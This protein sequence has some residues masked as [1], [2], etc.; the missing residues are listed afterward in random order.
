MSELKDE[1]GRR[2]EE[3]E[4]RARQPGRT[5]VIDYLNL[6]AA[7][8]EA[9]LSGVEW[10]LASFVDVAGE[11]NRRAT[12]ASINVARQENHRFESGNSSMVGTPLILTPG[13]ALC[14][15]RSWVAAAHLKTASCPGRARIRASATFS[16]NSQAKPGN[17]FCQGKRSRTRALDLS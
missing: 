1:W 7:N 6:R 8:D 12:T 9:R 2:L 16:G 10:L 15:D 11:A 17:R 13:G 5:D 14:R 4:N 3:A